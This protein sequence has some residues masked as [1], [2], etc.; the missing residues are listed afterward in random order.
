M[1]TTLIVLCALWA[2]LAY[3]QIVV[4]D[5][6]T[7][8]STAAW[9]TT[10]QPGGSSGPGAT[11]D[12]KASQIDV[13]GIDHVDYDQTLV[14]D[15][16]MP[17]QINIDSG[18]ALSSSLN[19]EVTFPNVARI[20]SNFDLIEITLQEISQIPGAGLSLTNLSINGQAVP[21]SWSAITPGD[22]SSQYVSFFLSDYRDIPLTINGNLTFYTDNMVHSR[23]SDVGVQ[24]VVAGYQGTVQNVP[25]PSAIFQFVVGFGILLSRC[26]RRHRE[27]GSVRGQL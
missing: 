19:G 1:K 27:M 22:W 13:A 20:T 3:G 11:A 25:E 18:A 15:A 5:S 6:A 2:Q 24:L 26:S 9:I 12:D 23:P 14:Y 10:F 16:S 8:T 17:F 21:G 4:S 7:L